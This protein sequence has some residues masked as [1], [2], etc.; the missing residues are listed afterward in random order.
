MANQFYALWGDRNADYEMNG[1]LLDFIREKVGLKDDKI[2]WSGLVEARDLEESEELKKLLMRSISGDHISF[3]STDR[4]K[5]S[6]GR[7]GLDYIKLMDNEKIKIVDAVVYP[8]E[9]EI[10]NLVTMAG[11]EIELVPFG[12]GTT[13]TGGV[14]PSGTRKFSVSI[15][16]ERLDSIILYSGNNVLE[17]GA[18]V[19]GPKLE[20]EINKQG[21]TLGNFPE[22]F[23]YSTIGG[24]IA[25]NAAGQESNRYGKIRDMIIGLR[26]QSPTGTY[27]DVIVP[28][29]SAFFRLSDIATGSEGAFGIIT[30]AWLKVHKKPEKMFYRAYMFN[31]FSEGLESL[32]KKF[33]SG[34][35]P[36]ISRLSDEDET[37]LSLMGVEDKFLNNLFKRYVN[38][39][40]NGKKGAML[41]AIS[42]RDEEIEFESG[43][44]LGSL[45]A[46]FWE[47]E[48]YS[49]PMMYNELLKRGIV[50]ETI[51]TSATWDKLS[52]LNQSTRKVF[53][54]VTEALNIKGL[55]LCHSS[56]QYVTGSALYFTFI[57]YSNDHRE[58]ALNKIRDGIMENIL[59]QGGSISHHHGIGSLQSKYLRE[60]KGNLYGVIEN[61]KNY[62]DPK[63]SLVPGVLRQEK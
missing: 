58:S 56:H 52:T 22:S 32:R 2:I 39:R 45:P 50:A 40:M 14:S 13:V 28:G 1:T 38:F 59:A 21:M 9:D 23:Y 48:R 62:F 57:F 63:D 35:M 31:S 37:E 60:Y 10:K 49:R 16:T 34:Q 33:T 24:W 12:G 3:D 44:S 51:E 11:D 6:I 25:T 30:R 43:L 7:G 46:K 15:D 4:L 61:M 54:E 17:V 41:I 36:T 26:M 47:R 29:E 27:Q 55:L 53:F 42:D 18:G 8:S 20:E 19:K 5:H